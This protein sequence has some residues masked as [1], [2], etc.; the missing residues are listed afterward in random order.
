MKSYLLAFGKASVTSTA[1]HLIH[2]SQP[3]KIFS[4]NRRHRKNYAF[5]VK[6][7]ALHYRIITFLSAC[8]KNGRIPDLQLNFVTPQVGFLF[9]RYN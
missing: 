6:S 9:F 2:R 3:R 1:I 7:Q 4:E 5:P 8:F